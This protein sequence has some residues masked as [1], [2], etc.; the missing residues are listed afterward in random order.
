MTD[1]RLSYIVAAARYGSFTRAAAQVGVTQSAIT[2]SV[3]DLERQLG[4]EIFDR[5][6][7]G[8]IM[9]DEGKLFVERAARLLEE[10]DELL[11]VGATSD[12]PYADVL[13]IGVCPNSIEWLLLAPLRKL[14]ARYPQIRLH[15]SG[16]TS[17]QVIR[18]LRTGTIDVAFGYDAAFGEH[19]DIDRQSLAPIRTSLFVRQG[20]PLLDL[21][22]VTS[23]DI[24]QYDIVSPS[25]SK[26]YDTFI[27]QIYEENFQ[28]PK[29]K[30]HMTDFFPLVTHLVLQ[31]DAIG[32]V[33]VSYSKSS[34]FKASFATIPY[35]E[36]LLPE[37]LC[38]AV[39]R[40][41][42][43]RPAARAF[44]SACRELLPLT[45]AASSCSD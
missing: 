16:A 13:R 11:G 38:C 28:S 31:T 35:L 40:R 36:T 4:Y 23:K 39:R 12:D 10:T 2:K 3:A 1:R 7:R 5:T 25:L 42:P 30:I 15:V 29:N 9:T 44:I 45:E 18:Q 21:E 27:Y 14:M 20:H 33:D 24:A 34:R 22:T 43:P 41:W 8:I 17:E 37:A 26:P 32:F 19:P 6:A